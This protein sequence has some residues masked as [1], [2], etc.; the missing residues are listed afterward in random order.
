MLDQDRKQLNDA[1][2]DAV[3]ASDGPSLVLAGAGSGKTRVLT[4]RAAYLIRERGV[5]PEHILLATFT[6]KAASEMRGRLTAM[7][8]TATPH[9]GTFHSMCAKVLRR[10]GKHLGLAPSYTILDDNDAQDAIK[11]ALRLL[12]L[13]KRWSPGAIASAISQAKNE[14]IGPAEYAQYVRGAFQETVARVYLQY[15]KLL[16]EM[17]AADFDDLIMHT[18]T[19]FQRLPEI[20]QRYQILWHH[21]LVDEYQDVNNAQYVLTKLLAKRFRNIYVVGDP[22]QSVYSFRGADFRNIVNFK[23]DYPEA[24]VYNLTQNYRSTQIILDA[25]YAVIHK[26]LLHPILK[27]TTKNSGGQPI[28]LYEAASEQS[29]AEFILATITG[30]ERP[31]F[32]F[33]ILYRTNAQSRVLEEAFLHAGVPYRLV[34]GT[35]FYQRK[36]VK[37]ILAYVRL[38]S[39]RKDALSHKRVEKLGKGRLAAFLIYQKEAQDQLDRLTTIEILD[40]TLERTAYLEL[41]DPETPE[42][43]MRRENVKE[44]RSVAQEFLHL[45]E[46][47]ESVA[48]VEREYDTRQGTADAVTLMTLHAAKGLEFPVVFMVG[49]EEGLFP[50]SR[51][52]LSAAE[53]EEER[54]LCYVGITRAKEQLY[55]TYAR[56][57]RIFGVTASGIVS[58][59]IIDIPEKLLTMPPYISPSRYAVLQD[60]FHDPSLYPIQDDSVPF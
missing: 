52:M 26:N 12:Q 32:D 20:L 27:L 42:G 54:R 53:L 1:Q 14:L 6:N 23:T 22:Q 46:F 4:H 45:P 43:Q 51:S 55:L 16:R 5:S 24:K 35:P 13:P 10:E 38:I 25:A 9:A 34:G 40:N 30:S 59:F 21:I 7:V 28:A 58:R 17:D 11:E 33:A 36:E 8:G 15:T 60:N 44:L 50:H 57:R 39:N 2:R 29:E 49:M 31:K 3:S 48:L 18:V 19:L 56:S 37:D 47:L 41:L